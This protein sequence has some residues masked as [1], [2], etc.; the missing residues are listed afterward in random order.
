FA[1][2]PSKPVL[3]LD[4]L[5]CSAHHGHPG[6]A[7]LESLEA[8]ERFLAVL[9][10]GLHPACEDTKRLMLLGVCVHNV[11]SLPLFLRRAHL[12]NLQLSPAIPRP[13]PGACYNQH[14]LRGQ[15]L[16]CG[17]AV[18][19]AL[20]LKQFFVGHR[21]LSGCQYALAAVA[22]SVPSTRRVVRQTWA[23]SF[24]GSSWA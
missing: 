7:I 13:D 1:F 20:G 16:S 15:G 9:P 21:Y 17:H 2:S 10:R 19:E 6:A 8:T 24:S 23:S 12:E 11:F 18:H 14:I 5:R 3:I 4:K 22:A